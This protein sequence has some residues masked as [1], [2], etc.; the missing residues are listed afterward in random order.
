[1]KGERF[2][3]GFDRTAFFLGSGTA[4]SQSSKA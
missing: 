2:S 1:M 4:S 3:A